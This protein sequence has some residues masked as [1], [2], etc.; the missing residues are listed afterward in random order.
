LLAGGG[1]EMA[2]GFSCE[3]AKIEEF[4]NLIN[5]KLAKKVEELSAVKILE[6]SC[7][8][9]IPEITMDFYNELQRLRPFGIGNLKP[10]F[11]VEKLEIAFWKKRGDKHL[12]VVLIDEWGQSIKGMFFG[13]FESYTEEFLGNLTR[14]KISVVCQI[15]MNNWNGANS[16][17]LNIVDLKFN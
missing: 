5:K 9:L 11:L 14:E 8:I 7:E 10:H 6:Y 17:E 2:G 4:E 16:L 3:I 12:F 1:H 15:S 13:F